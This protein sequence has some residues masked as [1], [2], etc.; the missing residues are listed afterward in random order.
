MKS[1]IVMAY[2]TF[3]DL[4]CAE[5]ICRE[6]LERKLIACA[7]IQSPN[8]ALYR[9]QGSVQKETEVSAWLKTSAACQEPLKNIFDDL[10]PYDVPCLVFATLLDSLPE[11]KK[12]VLNELQ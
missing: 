2:C 5:R 1:E 8:V 3:P 11:Y 4:E 9:W 7:N 10:H 12:W 6:L